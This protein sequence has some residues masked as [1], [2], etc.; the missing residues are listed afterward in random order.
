[1][2]MVRTIVFN[3]VQ[4]D[5]FVSFSLCVCV[6]VTVGFAEDQVFFSEGAGIRTVSVNINRA[7]AT[8]FDVRVSGGLLLL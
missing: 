8:G 7:I 5:I 6:D 3:I 4:D 1:M 2:K